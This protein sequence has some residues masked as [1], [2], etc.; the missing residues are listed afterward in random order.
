MRQ[1]PVGK[2]ISA[3][4]IRENQ[5]MRHHATVGCPITTGIFASISAHEAEEEALEGRNDITSTGGLLKAVAIL[6]KKSRGVEKRRKLIEKEDHKI[7]QKG[8]NTS[9]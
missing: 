8:E 7:I 4:E 2:L 1:V 3:T 6:M 5:A 9:F